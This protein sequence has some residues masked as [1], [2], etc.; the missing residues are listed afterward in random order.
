MLSKLLKLAPLVDKPTSRGLTA[1][2]AGSNN[3]A[4]QFPEDGVI[5]VVEERTK[6]QSTQTVKCGPE[7]IV[8]LFVRPAAANS[9][10]SWLYRLREAQELCQCPGIML[11]A[12]LVEGRT[13]KLVSKSRGT[14]SKRNKYRQQQQQLPTPGCAMCHSIELV[15]RHNQQIV[16]GT[17]NRTRRLRN[18]STRAQ[19]MGLNKLACRGNSLEIIESQTF[20]I[21]HRSM[22]CA[23]NNQPPQSNNVT[24]SQR[25]FV[26]NNSLKVKIEIETSKQTPKE[27]SSDSIVNS[28]P[29]NNDNIRRGEQFA[30]DIYS[31]LTFEKENYYHEKMTSTGDWFDKTGGQMM[32]AKASRGKTSTATTTTATSSS[33][34]SFDPTLNYA[35]SVTALKEQIARAK[36]KFFSSPLS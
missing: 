29:I 32:V 14:N 18:S 26:L 16:R 22:E 25:E 28:L 1:A 36:A 30:N 8:N 10:D 23:L 12:P 31:E 2:A 27:Q 20:D 3:F 33:S 17:S 21:D 19:S 9:E 34:T 35:N 5:D 13:T 6:T 24:S 7:E 4:S 15:G 11:G